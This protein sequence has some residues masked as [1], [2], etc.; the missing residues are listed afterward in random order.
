VPGPHQITTDIGGKY[1]LFVSR[2]LCRRGIDSTYS[3]LVGRAASV[4]RAICGSG[5]TPV[6]NGGGTQLIATEGS[7]IGP[8]GQSVSG[9]CLAYYFY[10]GDPGGAFQFAIQ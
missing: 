2:D 3:I 6:L 9:G 8:G 10:E 4:K 5:R 1:C 7:R